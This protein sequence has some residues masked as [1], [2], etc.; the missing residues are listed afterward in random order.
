MY[1]NAQYHWIIAGWRKLP[2]FKEET[3][4]KEQITS[5]QLCIKEAQHQSNWLEHV[6][7]GFTVVESVAPAH[8]HSAHYHVL[9]EDIRTQPPVEII[10]L[11]QRELEHTQHESQNSTWGK[12]TCRNI[13]SVRCWETHHTNACFCKQGA[14]RASVAPLRIQPKILGINEKTGCVALIVLLLRRHGFDARLIV[15][16]IIC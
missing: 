10:A 3:G 11:V 7:P 1:L 8:L 2:K 6:L 12:N 9:L 5:T 16:G 15:W 4:Q 13:P 14:L